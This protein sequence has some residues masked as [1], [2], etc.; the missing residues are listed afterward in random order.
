MGISGCQQTCTGIVTRCCAGKQRLQCVHRAQDMHSFQVFQV[1]VS[2]DSECSLLQPDKESCIGARQT[3]AWP[4]E[5][6]C[7][8]GVRHLITVKVQ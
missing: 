7:H 5:Q 1:L 2:D 6:P 8:E 3:S 4:F